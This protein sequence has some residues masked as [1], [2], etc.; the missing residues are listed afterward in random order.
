LIIRYNS[1]YCC[2]NVIYHVLSINLEFIR[3]TTAR[4]RSKA[5]LS[6]APVAVR[7]S[8]AQDNVQDR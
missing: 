6:P 8:A 7:Q 5:R 1:L 4:R 3:G 2:F